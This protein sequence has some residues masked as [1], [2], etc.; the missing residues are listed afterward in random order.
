MPQKSKKIFAVAISILA[1]CMAVFSITGARYAFAANQDATQASTK[2]QAIVDELTGTVTIENAT[3]TNDTTEAIVMKSI[4]FNLKDGIDDGKCNWDV[5]FDGVN[6]YSGLAGKTVELGNKIG[7]EPGQSLLVGFKTDVTP[8]VAKSL[9]GKEVAVI[10]YG[11][12]PAP[13]QSVTGKVVDKN[14]NPVPN[15]KVAIYNADTGERIDNGTLQSDT[16]GNYTYNGKLPKNI[17]ITYE[18]DNNVAPTQ[19]IENVGYD[20]VVVDPVIAKD[21]ST[22]SGHIEDA[23]STPPTSYT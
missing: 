19:I 3:V 9:I 5:A 4:A 14:G 17:I 20:P 11:T 7:V 12:A 13:T 10:S 21:K 16:N 18:G 22:L 23:P 8:K 6:V 2:V 1:L 15:V